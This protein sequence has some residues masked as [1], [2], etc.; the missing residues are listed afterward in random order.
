MF[1]FKFGEKLHWKQ[2]GKP[3]LGDNLAFFI[4]MNMSSRYFIVYLEWIVLRQAILDFLKEC[5]ISDATLNM[6]VKWAMCLNFK[7]FVGS[8]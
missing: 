8:V 4:I 2:L 6:I 5:S 7:A 3:P 1:H